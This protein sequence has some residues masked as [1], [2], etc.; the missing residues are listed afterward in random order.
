M[1]QTFRYIW[2]TV[3]DGLYPFLTYFFIK[4]TS[5]S[6]L[7]VEMGIRILMLGL[8]AK[9]FYA[10]MRNYRASFNCGNDRTQASLAMIVSIL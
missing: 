10:Q 3:G 2:T 6:Q 8:S 9:E 4:T 7:I 5:E 1:L